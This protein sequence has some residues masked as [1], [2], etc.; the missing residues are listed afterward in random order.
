M[1]LMAGLYEKGL[2]VPKDANQARQWLEKAKTAAE[3][4]KALREAG[5]E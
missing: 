5:A 1:K 2:G 3:T 4:E